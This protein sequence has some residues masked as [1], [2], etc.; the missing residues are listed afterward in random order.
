MGRRIRMLW[1][2]ARRGAWYGFGRF[3]GAW[4]WG[5]THT[6]CRKC[7]RP[8]KRECSPMCSTCQ[9]SNLLKALKE[10]GIF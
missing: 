4:L 3:S 8:K 6:H 9:I 10:E 5:L 2:L 7:K 1:S